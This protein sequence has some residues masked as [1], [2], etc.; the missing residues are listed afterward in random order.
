[1]FQK[2]EFF[3]KPSL[4]CSNRECLYGK[5]DQ[6]N[7]I[8]LYSIFTAGRYFISIFYRLAEGEK[9][10]IEEIGG[11]DYTLDIKLNP[12][13]EREDR[14]NCDAGRLPHNL[15]ELMEASDI[16]HYSDMIF[17]DF[18]IKKQFAEVTIDKPSV[19]RITCLEPSGMNVDLILKDSSGIISK[20]NAIGGAEGILKEINPGSY[21]IEISFLNS[22]IEDAH[23]KFCETIFLEIGIS[24][25]NSIKALSKFYSLAD[26]DNSEEDLLDIFSSFG[27]TLTTKSVMIKPDDSFFTLPIKN[28]AIGET[29]IFRSAFYIPRLVHS[30]FEIYSDFIMNDLMI[31]LEKKTENDIEIFKGTTDAL[32]IG[33]HGRRSFF[34]ELEAGT[35][36]FIIKTGPTAKILI[37]DSDIYEYFHS[38]QEYLILPR[39]AHFQLRIDLI[40][41]NE[42]FMKSW[43]CRGIDMKLLPTTFNTIDRLGI[44]NAP[45]EHMPTT[46]FFSNA[47]RAP[48]TH[49]NNTYSASIYLESDSLFRVLTESEDSPLIIAIKQDSNII[50]SEGSISSNYPYTY[51]FSALLQSHN[52]YI[53]EVSY[54]PTSDR[55][56]F[57]SLFIEI[58]PTKNIRK[59]SCKCNLNANAKCFD[60]KCFCT[61]PY[62]GIDCFDCVDG[63]Q[64]NDGICVE[65]I[66]M[67]PQIISTRFNLNKSVEKHQILELFAE[68]TSSP[69]GKDEEKITKWKSKDM[70]E[71]FLLISDHY[72]VKP[73]EAAPLDNINKHWV[74]KYLSEDL[75]YSKKYT[76]KIVSGLLFTLTGKEF[77]DIT[78]ELSI[79][80]E[81]ITEEIIACNG[82]GIVKDTLCICDKGYKGTICDTCEDNYKLNNNDICEEIFHKIEIDKNAYIKSISP[83]KL[84]YIKRGDKITIEIELSEQAYTDKGNII[85]RLTN[86]QYL[87]EMFFLHKLKSEIHIKPI[88]VINKDKH[89][90][91][92]V[93]NFSS[94]SLEINKVY[95]FD[96]TEDILYTNKGKLFS[97]GNIINM[98][99]FKI[100]D[101]IQCLNGNQEGD[102]CNCFIGYA[103]ESCELCD[104][105]YIKTM[106]GIC[107]L[108]K[109]QVTNVEFGKSDI[110]EYLYL[111]GY[112]IIVGVVLYLIQMLRKRKKL[113][114]DFE[115]EETSNDKESEDIDLY[116]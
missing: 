102:K 101:F 50:A 35:Y 97:Y 93:V 34:G 115:L 48:N 9:E 57:F 36:Y 2:G 98:P 11:I 68:F 42:Q 7:T 41:T 27:D 53:F 67:D 83:S 107:V 88:S 39:C 49:I 45:Q 70:L 16:L 111:V 87:L 17:A 1:M 13:F 37:N 74:I 58:L 90:V 64:S 112:I 60:N 76:L 55:C 106:K 114:K 47:V 43:N 82:H 24:P 19:I 62:N 52:E 73:Y 18:T 4:K 72:T 5:H 29:I 80:I 44:K 38:D 59:T 54:Y 20:S 15:N 14:F 8:T 77:T 12:I 61:S 40:R 79:N 31:F 33:E 65:I 84:I 85:D 26:C 6:K 51:S 23:Q 63:Y 100:N 66:D 32:E 108:D 22:F 96:Q 116:I 81:A 110:N 75:T 95:G 56:H 71:A 78:K 91:K 89:G 46:I 104:D 113:E 105:E 3:F 94:E 30:Y 86:S 109:V 69:Y 28:L 10:I 103:G 92:W 99:K 21:A 25:Q